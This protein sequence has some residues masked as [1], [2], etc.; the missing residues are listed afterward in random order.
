MFTPDQLTL[1][2]IKIVKQSITNRAPKFVH[3]AGHSI[4][5]HRM[6]VLLERHFRPDEHAFLLLDANDHGPF[7]YP[8]NFLPVMPCM[9]GMP[10]V[11]RLLDGAQ[12]I[13]VHSIWA[14]P[15][16]DLLLA[17]PG[18]PE[19]TR[20]IAW[21]AD[22]YDY[23]ATAKTRA[24][25]SR[26]HG[27]VAH[28]P[29]EWRLAREKFGADLMW[30]GWGPFYDSG[31]MEP[32]YGDLREPDTATRGRARVLVG[33]RAY[34]GLRHREI[35]RMLGTRFPN[36]LDVYSVLAYG[37]KDYAGK[38]ISEGR[39]IFGENFH[40]VTNFVPAQDYY[41]FLKGMDVGIFA[42]ER[43]QGLGN[44]T[45]L[46]YHGKKVFI[47]KGSPNSTF[48]S[49]LGAETGYIEDLSDLDFEG[50]VGAANPMAN[51]RAMKR[52]KNG[53]LARLEWQKLL[54]GTPLRKD[55]GDLAPVYADY[56]DDRL[57][58]IAKDD[59]WRQVRRTRDGLPFPDEQM[60]IIYGEIRK[61]LQFVPDDVLLD[62][63]CGNGRL[64]QEFVP[65]VAGYQ[66]VDLSPRLIRVA[67]DN[68]SSCG[69]SF[70][71]GDIEDWLENAANPEKYTKCLIYGAIA[72]FS[73][74]S[75]HHIL[76]LL[77]RRFRN[78]G[79]V[80]IGPVP[81]KDRCGEFYRTND[82]DTGDFT[83]SIGMWHRRDDFMRM[84]SD[85]GWQA[86]ILPLPEESWQAGYRFNV[87][88][89]RNASTEACHEKD[90]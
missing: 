72:Y 15:F 59:Y 40:P 82:H 88:L 39:E 4:F 90:H 49:I 37:D 73:V 7:A 52:L 75:I 81:D 53:D 43:S 69:S 25:V 86:E 29:E 45:C 9:L 8:Q 5:M 23:P 50:F 68:F 56:S 67:R 76:L 77:N 63:A 21:G 65:S 70:A 14:E 47:R 27:V 6:S 58:T 74:A 48:L 57:E 55:G 11:R 61:A 19:K 66:G 17:T 20:W 54:Y 35:F 60:E 16:T 38:V 71:E 36:K 31:E 41:E 1:S 34:E 44:I 33:H 2:R 87:I 84:A 64:A 18:A 80:F 24:L 12:K 51:H 42:Q 10:G 83:S 22:L 30:V 79:R 13:F 32:A 85:C 62:L 89:T 46:L 3:L 26:L 78:V 28:T